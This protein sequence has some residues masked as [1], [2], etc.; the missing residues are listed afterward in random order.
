MSYVSNPVIFNSNYLE[1]VQGLTVLATDSYKPAKR[2][3]STANLARS[4]NSV[5]NSAFYNKLT[6]VVKVGITRNT[7]AQLETSVD[8]LMTMLQGINKILTLVQ[9]GGTRNYYC[10]FIDAPASVDGGSYIEL[11]LVFECSD[12]FGYSTVLSTLLSITTSFT[13]QSRSD[14]LLF[15]GSA[16][17]QAPVIRLTFSSVAGAST[18]IVTIGN[19]QTGQQISITRVWSNGDFLEIDC[20][21]KTVRV[22]NLDV[23]FDGAIPRWATGYGYWYYNDTFT[24]RA[25]TGNITY[26]PRYI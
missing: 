4:S 16:P 18:R 3:L 12:R 2:N 24:S 15:V 6:I 14:Q 23:D 19:G 7:R 13:S 5:H 25:F 11:D 10:T 26:Y 9:S 8:S 17:T 21:N 1:T 22:N 20:L